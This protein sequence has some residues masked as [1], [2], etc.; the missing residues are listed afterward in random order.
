[1][2]VHANLGHGF[3]EAVYQEA[4]AAEFS[5]RAI[6]FIREVDLPV[7]YKGQRLACAYRADFVCYDIVL[8]ETKALGDLTGKE[9]SQVI[10]YLKVTGYP[11][12]LLLN[13]SVPS[14]QYKRFAHTNKRATVNT[15]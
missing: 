1:M 3:L 14:L 2:E 15:E 4:L 13:F 11:R 7:I 6:H 5:L 9:E 12:A 8:A 10:N